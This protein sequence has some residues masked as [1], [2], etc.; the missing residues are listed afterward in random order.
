MSKRDLKNYLSELN[1]EQLEEQ[2]INLYNKFPTVKTFFDFVFK[3]NER[4]L[5]QDFKLKVSN[6]YFPVKIKKAKARRSVAQKMIKHFISLGVDPFV[7]VDAMLY[8]IEIAQTYSSEK[9][10]KQELFFKSMLNSFQQAVSFMIEKGVLYDFKNRV[11]AIRAEAENQDW[12]NIFE[13][14]SIVEKFDY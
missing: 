5:L 10:I 4:Q 13:F 14:N 3:P 12:F 9:E 6:E 2:V 7:I 11:E 8:S 1:K